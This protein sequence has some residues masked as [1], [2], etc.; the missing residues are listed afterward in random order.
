MNTE[1][2]KPTHTPTTWLIVQTLWRRYFGLNVSPID[3]LLFVGGEFRSEQWPLLHALGIRAVL[4]LQAEHV[5]NFIGPPPDRELRLEVIDHT[6]PTLDQLVAGVEFIVQC[7]AT[8]LP[9][10]V[11]CHAG[12]GR[13]PL[14]AA[15]YLMARYTLSHREALRYVRAARPI[16]NV[17]TLQIQR[18]REWEAL[19]R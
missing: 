9:V 17:N 3:H 19:I 6:A 11:H 8:R 13:A 10:L 15:A 18:L 16:V 5:D 12:V 1:Q 4:S 7:H 2:N 14:T